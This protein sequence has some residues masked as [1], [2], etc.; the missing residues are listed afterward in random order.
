MLI[1][2]FTVLAQLINFLILIY[3]LKRF[4]YG[5]IIKAMDEREKKVSD[6]L[7]NAGKAEKEARDKTIEIEKE[8][9]AFES[10]KENMMTEAREEVSN[11][12]KKTIED[13]RA[14]IEELR[15]KWVNLLDQEKDTF[16]RGVRKTVISGIMKIGEKV[17]NDLAREDIEKQIITVFLEK[18]SE[19]SLDIVK[20]NESSDLI[21]ETGFP[22]DETMVRESR[23]R[24]MK[25]LPNIK[26]VNFQVSGELGIGIRT[27]VGDNRVEWNLASYLKGFE[28]EI[29]RDLSRISPENK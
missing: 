29:F 18:L 27:K 12:R 26:T 19:N 21:I 10:A 4:L 5:P 15:E 17:L 3:L 28:K 22:L 25:L 23:E 14:E 6:T 9:D 24:V 16:I 8:K 13:T 1:N 11:W 2:W 7:K 20:N